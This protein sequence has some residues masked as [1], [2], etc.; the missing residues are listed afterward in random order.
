MFEACRI[1]LVILGC[2][3]AV[4]GTAMVFLQG[5]QPLS[6]IFRLIDRPFWKGGPDETTRQFERWSF[7]VT[8][9]VMA[10]W[11]ICIASI[12]ANAF[13]T[14]ELW[15]WWTIAGGMLLW[16]PLDT[17]RSLYHRVY[18]NAAGN[19]LMLAAM[20]IPLALTFGEFR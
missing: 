18:A 12:A 6:P 10:G 7:G 4:A 9:A 8:F 11:G 20:V 13:A 1:W 2:V 15:A 5:I 3:M 14:R 17:G 19:T 16:Y